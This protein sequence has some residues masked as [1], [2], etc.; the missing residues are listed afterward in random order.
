MDIK[1]YHTISILLCLFSGENCDQIVYGKMGENVY[2][3]LR[4][5]HRRSFHAIKWRR[6][7]IVIAKTARSSKPFAEVF[8]NGTL[9]LYNIGRN[10]SGVYT[11]EA[12]DDQ[13]IFVLNETS[14]LVVIDP[15]VVELVACILDVPVL[16]CAGGDFPDAVYEWRVSIQNQ[17]RLKLS[18]HTGKFL[19]LEYSPGNISCLL[20]M[21]NYSSQSSSYSLSCAGESCGQTVYGKIG[22][23]VYLHLRESHGRSFHAIKWRRQNIVI[24]KTARSS[25]PFAEVFPNGTLKLY[26]IGRNCSGVYTAEAHDDQGF[27]VFKE[28]SHLVVID[29][30]VVELVVCT[31]DV[32]VL[33]CA[34]ENVPDAVY[35][36]RVSV[37]NEGRLK[38]SNHTGK[39]VT[40]DYSTGNISCSLEIGNYSSQSASY[41]LSCA[42]S[43]RLVPEAQ[44]CVS[45]GV[46]VMLVLLCFM[47]CGI[48][49]GVQICR[50]QQNSN[51]KSEE[52]GPP[53]EMTQNDEIVYSEVRVGKRRK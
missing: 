20:K 52:R 6:Q 19:A 40:L 45:L 16:H 37:Q 39:F 33:H 42:G 25:K 31:P 9:K 53:L 11:A 26:N 35:T 5:S 43:A 21:G 4:E 22:E 7:N 28:S 30:P 17:G 50:K 1:T 13:G 44:W 41:S 23:N 2:L 46:T 12:Y 14:H 10:H 8:P 29:P 34:G 49:I 47:A 36:W 51:V 38:V 3:H 24:A 18:N 15:P 27:F 48:S 32:S